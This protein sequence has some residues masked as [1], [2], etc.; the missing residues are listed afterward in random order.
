MRRIIPISLLLVA[1]AL[2]AG[3]AAQGN[4]GGGAYTE[5]PPS[6]GGDQGTGT[7]SSGTSGSSSGSSGNQTATGS[8]STTTPGTT[9]TTPG[10]TTT[11][12]SGSTLT[13]SSAGESSAAQTGSQSGQ[14]PMTG[15]NTLI[16]VG[17]AASLLGAG[18]VMR[19]R[20]RLSAPQAEAGP[21]AYLSALKRISTSRD[22]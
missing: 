21:R 20:A 22:E 13:E 7:G 12:S 9:T 5:N 15:S 14:L 3:A 6:A 17:I 1:L 11:T 4:S 8:T 10:E 2:P 19:R 18:V 16:L